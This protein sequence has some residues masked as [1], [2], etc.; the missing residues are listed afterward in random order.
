MFLLAGIERFSATDRVAAINAKEHDLTFFQLH[1]RSEAFAAFL[2]RQFGE[3]RAPVVIHGHKEHDILCCMIGALKAGR[4]Y[5]PVDITIPPDRISQIMNES[6]PDL[7]VSFP[8]LELETDAQILQ[9]S[10]LQAILDAP[11]PQ[12]IDRSIW[13]KGSDPAYILYTSGTTGVPK[14]VVICVDNLESLFHSFSS[15]IDGNGTQTLL[16]LASYS[17]DAS[18]FSIYLGLGHGMTLVSVEHDLLANPVKLFEFLHGSALESWVSTPSFA[19]YCFGTKGLSA[20]VLPNL[21]RFFFGGEVLTSALCRKIRENFPDVVIYNLYGPTEATLMVTEVKLTDA[22]I[23]G[24]ESIPIGAPL[25]SAILQ[26]ENDGKIIDAENESGELLILGDGVGRGY[27]NP[28]IDA[29]KRFFTDEATGKRGYHSGDL[30]Y[31]IGE[32]YYY[33]G[34]IDTQVKINGYRIELEDVENNL[35]KIDNVAK[36]VVLPMD[37]ETGSQYLMA[38]ILLNEY[39]KANRLKEIMAIKKQAGALLPTYMLP[40]VIKFVEQFPLNNN[41]KIDRKALA[42]LYTER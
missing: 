4:P 25:K 28:L 14:G 9:G 5:V 10:E 38:L 34:R 31:R 37:D 41:G 20:S 15:H 27:F 26:L 11:P 29:N 35:S 36:A 40:R 19:E 1:R 17:F 30:C 39:D 3:S 24:S 33:I 13:A 2:L 6:K 21:K 12:D 16:N 42:T 32:F 23:N 7:I 8:L 18:V 22:M